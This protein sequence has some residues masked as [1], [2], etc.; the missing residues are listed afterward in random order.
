MW[1]ETF[2]V[3]LHWLCCKWPLSFHDAL[4]PYLKLII[5]ILELLLET[6]LSTSSRFS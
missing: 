1:K 4:L 6:L 2:S 5:E 3:T